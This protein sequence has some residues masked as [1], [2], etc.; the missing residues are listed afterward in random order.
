MAVSAT[1]A[2]RPGRRYDAVA[3]HALLVAFI[4]V[5]QV[6]YTPARDLGPDNTWHYRLAHEIVTGVPVYWAGLDGNRLFPDLL[7]AIAAFVL[8]GQG[9]FEA[10]LPYFYVLFFLATYLSLVALAAALYEAVIERRAFVLLAV[11]GFWAF[12]LVAPFWPRWFFDPGNHG[13]GLPVALGCLALVFHMNRRGRFDWPSALVFVA[14]AALVVGS[15][16]FLLIAFLGPLLVALIVLL[17]VQRAARRDM[18][19][20]AVL[21]PPPQ[22]WGPLPAL[23]LTVAVAVA[24]SYLAYR[25]LSTLSWHKGTTFMGVSILNQNLSLRWAVEKLGQEAADLRAFFLTMNKQVAVGPALLLATVLGSI[26]R[27]AATLRRGSPAP[28][29]DNRVVLGLLAAVSAALSVAFVV[30]GWDEK[31]EWRYRYLAMATAFAVV[32]LATFLVRP[33]LLLPRPGWFGAGALLAL[34][35][36]TV[37]PA[38]GNDA[39]GR[40]ERHRKFVREVD[41]LKQWV[42]VRAKA[43]PVRGLG[44]YWAAMDIT[45]R[46]GLRI[47]VVNETARP[48]FYN[49]NA[50][51]MCLGGYSFILRKTGPD[52]PR[53]GEIVALLGEPQATRTM[54]IEGH[55]GVEIMVY[56]P[57]VLQSRIV[58]DGRTEAARLFPGFSCP[59]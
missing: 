6:V 5:T 46:T 1:I 36:L 40:A 15:N 53:R 4:V 3:F 47:D 30:W 54:E 22:P 23:I 20:R 17:A 58:E 24:G 19:K 9:L 43:A 12:E 32:F 31:T 35:A 48:R 8:S 29:E 26:V 49:S 39:R 55:Q 50:G 37:I 18:L 13:T 33:A 45:S 42:A 14:A 27:L 38:T 7:F 44:E 56:D 59:G 51:A 21:T 10:W 57:A 28:L 52:S 16:R 11:A 25:M 34:A 2:A 41:E